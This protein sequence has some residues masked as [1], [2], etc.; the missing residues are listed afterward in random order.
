MEHESTWLYRLIIMPVI[1]IKNN[2][3]NIYIYVC[4]YIYIMNGKPVKLTY[5]H[6]GRYSQGMYVY[7]YIYIYIYIYS[8][9]IPAFMAIYKLHWLPIHSLMLMLCLTSFSIV[10]FSQC[11]L[12]HRCEKTFCLDS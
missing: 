11:C 9:G 5:S 3:V 8:L 4:V 2:Y 6:K 12:P 1:T 7:I 10:Q